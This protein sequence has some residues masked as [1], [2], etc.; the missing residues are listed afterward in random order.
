PSNSYFY[1][2]GEVPEEEI[3]SL[4]ERYLSRFEREEIT[5]DI[6]RQTPRAASRVDHYG[7]DDADSPRDIFARA[8]I[9]AS[10]DEI[11]RI[12]AVDILGDYLASTNESP[13]RRAVLSSGLAEDLDV[14]VFDGIKQAYVSIVARNIKDEDSGK[15]DGVVAETLSSIV[16]EGIP[17][18][19]LVAAINKFEFSFR[20]LSEPKGLVRNIIA[21][22]SWLY[23]GDPML[24]LDT[25]GVFR[26]LRA[27][28]DD[29][30]YEKLLAEVF[31][32]TANDVTLH[33]LASVTFPEEEARR[34]AEYAAGVYGAMSD[35]ERAALEEDLRELALRQSTPDSK[36]G[37][38]SIPTLPLSE[39][40]PKP[41]IYPTEE[42]E[43]RGVRTLRH[44]IPTNGIVYFSAVF[45]LTQFTAEELGQISLASSFYGQLPTKG[46][47]AATLQ[48]AVKTYLG[49][50]SVSAQSTS[51]NFD[52]ERAFPFLIVSASTLDENLPE[53]EALVGEILTDTL[54]DNREKMLE[55]VKQLD[56]TN[57]QRLVG[58]GHAAALSAARATLTS[59]GAA[60]DAISGVSFYKTVRE[61]VR[62]PGR[63]FDALTALVGRVGRESM[64]KE[65][66]ILSV[67]SPG[68]PD[69][70]AFASIF[71]SGEA[72]PK[73]AAYRSALPQRSSIKS[74]SAVSFAVAADIAGRSGVSYKGSFKVAA[75]ILS[76]SYLWDAVRVKGGAYGTGLA[77]TPGG[78]MFC[79]SYRDP[80]PASSLE[81]YGGCAD[82]LRELVESGESLDKYIISAGSSGDPLQTPRAEGATADL[83]ILSEISDEERAARRREMIET[84]PADLLLFADALDNMA[85]GGTVCV[86][87]GGADSVDGLTPVTI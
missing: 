22:D 5:W 28:I 51:L 17:R 39:V 82:Y 69:L 55:I 4:I 33:L 44:R 7:T 87:G 9:F 63:G 71:P 54:F 78:V 26:R 65:N 50:F 74:P 21:L 73:S 35:S 45:P 18:E 15:I 3:F 11:E 31:C 84:E 30:S 46:K 12:F 25:D 59:D 47:D 43:T 1:L 42:C 2:D 62:D 20:Q 16:K 60:T 64:T 77:V 52:P 68:E 13:L 72:L 53:A 76:L 86:V 14:S 36:E 66:A 23:G 32:D 19:D 48:R 57:R 38:A 61:V 34:E 10:F 80:S 29:G 8:K 70:S 56:E 27:M 85:S 6:P 79:Y 83:L 81:A 40:S 67:T 41:K 49:S 58:A 75:N 24:Y 37:I